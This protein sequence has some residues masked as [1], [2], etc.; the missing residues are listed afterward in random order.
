MGISIDQ[1]Q[2]K[3]INPP[4]PVQASFNDVNAAIACVT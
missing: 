2:L 3:N 4:E 1:V